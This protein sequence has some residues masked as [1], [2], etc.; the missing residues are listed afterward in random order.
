[1]KKILFVEDDP[2][3]GPVYES[4]LKKAGYHTTLARDGEA[5]LNALQR[6]IPDLVVLD[7]V[8]PKISG[9]ELLKILNTTDGLRN[10]PVIVF[11]NTFQQDVLA[12]VRLQN[13]QRILP[14]SRYVPREVLKIIRELL[15]DESTDA[16]D[17]QPSLSRGE[18]TARVVF[19]QRL[20]GLLKECRRMVVDANKQPTP[21]ARSNR[22]RSLRELIHSLGGGAT[23]AGLKI[24]AYFCE[25]LEA[26]IAEVAGEAGKPLGTSLRTITQAV[27]FLFEEFSSW[28]PND[29]PA[30]LS[31]NVLAVDDDAISRRAVCVALNRI[32]QKAVEA[33]S[34]IEALQQTRKQ[35]FDLIFLDVDMPEMNGFELCTEIRKTELNQAAP[36]IFVTGLT[37]LQS[38][39]NSMLSGGTDFI[40][41]PFQFM[42]L[43][44]K[45]LIHLL[46]S[47]SR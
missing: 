40:P 4:H 21:D 33:K 23:A 26:F 22:L 3:L 43:A 39:A 47:K 25:A 37:D 35:K 42:E 27:D 9:I 7:V 5:G 29:F 45:S 2:I 10:V 46:R 15:N 24:H 19:Q 38:R 34:A 32:N 44:V 16:S 6:G 11:T 28:K 36:I 30:D 1:M 8:L 18:S 12:E 17:N 13:P 20:P 14:K 41:K 31:F